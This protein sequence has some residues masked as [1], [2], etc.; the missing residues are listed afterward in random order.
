MSGLSEL[1]DALEQARAKARAIGWEVN[2]DE[3]QEILC[4]GR[5][6]ATTWRANDTDLIVAEHNAV[7]T[8]IAALRR[9]EAL[10]DALG[11]DFEMHADVVADEI[12]A[13]LNGD[14]L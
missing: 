7:P 12:R 2:P 3:E 9:V 4:R 11:G 10:A 13:A 5:S 14:P 8:L 6:V 1:L